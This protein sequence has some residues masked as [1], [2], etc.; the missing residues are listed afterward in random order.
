MGPL[1][2]F[3][4]AFGNADYYEAFKADGWMIHTVPEFD[5][6]QAPF[7]WDRLREDPYYN[8]AIKMRWEQLRESIFSIEHIEYIIDSLAGEITESQARNFETFPV[9]GTYIWPNYFIGDTWESE[10]QYMKD[11]IYNRITW[12]DNQIDL[13]NT[14]ED[15]IKSVNAYEISVNP[16]PFIEEIT[17]HVYF[18]RP[19]DFEI[20]IYNSIGTKIHQQTLISV[21][22]PLELTIPLSNYVLEKGIY[23]CQFIAEGEIVATRKLIKLQ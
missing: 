5:E 7:W 10:V 9:L 20:K 23:F 17:V 2:D 18:L 12:M 4:L 21:T 3:N 13:I 6:L 11:W 15:G 16:N 1:W 19:C 14:S 8:S 22:G